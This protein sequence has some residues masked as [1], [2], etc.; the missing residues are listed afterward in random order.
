VP[1]IGAHFFALQVFDKLFIGSDAQ[2]VAGEAVGGGL[3]E[4]G[5]NGLKDNPGPSVDY[6]VSL[7]VHDAIAT[8][9]NPPARFSK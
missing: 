1:S 8:H 7:V 6:S 5:G 9:G 2:D 4:Y 3:R